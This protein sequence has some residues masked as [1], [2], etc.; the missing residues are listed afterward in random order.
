MDQ[1]KKLEKIRITI[2]KAYLSKQI[3]GFIFIFITFIFVLVSLI[4]QI[5]LLFIPAI[6]S[7]VLSIR[8]YSKAAVDYNTFRGKIKRDLISHL[9]EESF[10][11]VTYKPNGYIPIDTILQSGVFKK[12]DHYVGEDLIEGVY[13][14]VRFRVSDVDLR[15]QIESRGASLH[16]SSSY[17][18]YFKGR[19][20][21]F[22]FEKVFNEVI[23]IVEESNFQV[24]HKD[25]VKVETESIEFNQKFT[26]WASSKTYAFYQITPVII[27][28]LLEIEKKHN[29]SIVYFFSKNELH[30]GINNRKDY[31]EISLKKVLNEEAVN[32]LMHEIEIIPTFIKELKLNSS[33]YI[34]STLGG[35]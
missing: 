28:K 22:T 19:W 17:H 5:P 12:P 3:I 9:V 7:T 6:P 33:K 24:N 10:K 30:I 35:M 21:V 1:L 34:D 32:E 4:G 27:E 14:N 20:Y 31:L 15:E 25:L 26:L 18:S 29:G 16:T 13:Q 2:Y 23:K 8:F 11:E